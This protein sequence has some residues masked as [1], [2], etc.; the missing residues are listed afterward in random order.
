[1]CYP[2]LGIHGFV[3]FPQFLKSV[4]KVK[5]ILHEWAAGI[6]PS[7]DLST[8]NF[9]E[10][11]GTFLFCPFLLHLKKDKKCAAVKGIKKPTNPAVNSTAES[12]C[13]TPTQGI[14]LKPLSR[15]PGCLCITHVY[16]VDQVVSMES[17]CAQ[18]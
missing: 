16:A 14:A 3:V 7:K 5:K 9:P 1:M 10:L 18:A 11:R 15:S 2:V 13:F 4:L 12:C 8:G 17:S 6:F